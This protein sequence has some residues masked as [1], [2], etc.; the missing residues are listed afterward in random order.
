MKT[1]FSLLFNGNCFHKGW[2]LFEIK[3]F[4]FE[5]KTKYN[6]MY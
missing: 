5:R 2:I 4:N 1:K 3:K 6:E